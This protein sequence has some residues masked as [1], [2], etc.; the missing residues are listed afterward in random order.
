MTPIVGY[1][2][3][4]G[5]YPRRIPAMG[6]WTEPVSGIRHMTPAQVSAAV[7]G[8]APAYLTDWEL[9]LAAPAEQRPVVLGQ[10][11]RRWQAT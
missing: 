9:W 11:L 3:E 4:A 8:F 5:K 7:S 6:L 10:I 1:W 2:T